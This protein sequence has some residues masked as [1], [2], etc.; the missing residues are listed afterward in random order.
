MKHKKQDNS[1]FAI[2]LLSN[3]MSLQYSHPPCEPFV[4]PKNGTPHLKNHFIGA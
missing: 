1:L 3:N 4:S 2:I